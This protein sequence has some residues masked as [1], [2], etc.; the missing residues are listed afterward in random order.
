LDIELFYLSIFSYY[1]IL[2]TSTSD[3]SFTN[4]CLVSLLPVAANIA[5][6]RPA[7]AGGSAG[8]PRPVGL[9]SFLIK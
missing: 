4:G 9:S 5:F 6:D 2:V 3:N 7:P 1:H 8:S